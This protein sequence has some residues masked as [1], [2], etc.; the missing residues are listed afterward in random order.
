[1]NEELLHWLVL[2]VVTDSDSL[3]GMEFTPCTMSRMRVFSYSV[4]FGIE[5]AL[6]NIVSEWFSLDYCSAT[7]IACSLSA[8]M[9]KTKCL[10]AS[11]K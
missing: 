9:S 10:S 1:M 11:F 2:S 8:K 7:C 5:Q 3:P 4:G 6:L